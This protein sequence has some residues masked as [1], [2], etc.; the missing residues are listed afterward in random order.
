MH[1]CV[2][3]IHA[4]VDVKCSSVYESGCSLIRSCVCVRACGCVQVRKRDSRGV[5]DLDLETDSI[6]QFWAGKL[7]RDLYEIPS[8][9]PIQGCDNTTSKI[10]VWGGRKAEVY[11]IDAATG[12]YSVCSSFETNATNMAIGSDQ[13]NDAVRL[14]VCV[15]VPA[16]LALDNCC[17]HGSRNW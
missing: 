4:C 10:V 5:A 12:E 7:D 14:C 8:S 1:S 17:K 13:Q 9:I 11:D 3:Y 15:C 6:Q 2:S 16:L